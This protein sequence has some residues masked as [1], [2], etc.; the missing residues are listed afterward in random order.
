M[1]STNAI[2]SLSSVS[3]TFRSGDSTACNQTWLWRSLVKLGH[4]CLKEAPSLGPSHSQLSEVPPSP[5]ATHRANTTPS[6][7]LVMKSRPGGGL[8]RPSPFFLPFRTVYLSPYK[9]QEM[10]LSF[11]RKSEDWSRAE[12]E[13]LY[14]LQSKPLKSQEFML[15]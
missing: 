2:G 13:T 14:F 11:N 6:I 10:P 8:R 1:L 9:R 3:L 4:L 12:I 7:S 5:Q 15:G